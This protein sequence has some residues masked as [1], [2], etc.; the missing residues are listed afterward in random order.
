MLGLTTLNVCWTEMAAAKVESHQQ[1]LSTPPAC[2]LGREAFGLGTHISVV[3]TGD[4]NRWI[5]VRAI[6]GDHG[7]GGGKW[8]GGHGDLG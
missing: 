1:S 3:A 5:G 4:P 6:S 2:A 8:G 7:L